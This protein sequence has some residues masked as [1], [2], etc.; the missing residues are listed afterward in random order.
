MKSMLLVNSFK[1]NT[2][3]LNSHT[4]LSTPEDVE[5]SVVFASDLSVVSVAST[6]WKDIQL[7]LLTYYGVPTM[8]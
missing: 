2:I 5:A 3:G 8:G 4:V 1:S 6:F 7:G